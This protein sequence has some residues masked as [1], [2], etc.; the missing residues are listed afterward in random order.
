MGGGA[1]KYAPRYFKIDWDKASKDWID[2]ITHYDRHNY[3]YYDRNIVASVKLEPAPNIFSIITY[4][5]FQI[6]G[7]AYY[8]IIAFSYIPNC[9]ASMQYNDPDKIKVCSFEETIDILSDKLNLSMEGI[10]EITEEEYY[11]ID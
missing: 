10:T 8:E 5:L 9:I 11:K 1:S 6:T 2:I 7:F 4:I 3:S